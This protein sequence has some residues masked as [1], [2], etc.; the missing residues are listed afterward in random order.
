MA[1]QANS[2]LSKEYAT[3]AKSPP[4]FVIA[5]PYESNLCG[6]AFQLDYT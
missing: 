1:K 3:L 2:R 5:R 6:A 4:P